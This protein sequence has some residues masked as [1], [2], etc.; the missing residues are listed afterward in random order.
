MRPMWKGRRK[1]SKGPPVAW[2]SLSKANIEIE[3]VSGHGKENEC[4]DQECRAA[5]LWIAGSR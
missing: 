1:S 4:G 2:V 5:R 3:G